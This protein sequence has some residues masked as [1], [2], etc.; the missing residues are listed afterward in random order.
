M[1]PSKKNKINKNCALTKKN[2]DSQQEKTK[3]KIVRPL[4]KCFSLHG[5]CDTIRISQ[6][7]QCLP[8]AGFFSIILHTRNIQSLDMC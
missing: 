2:L 4:F 1:T 3:I 8:Y 7:I 5:N 6:D